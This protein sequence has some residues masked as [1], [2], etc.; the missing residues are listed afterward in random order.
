MELYE[1]LKSN[2]LFEGI[3]TK[4]IERLLGCLQSYIKTFRKNE[5]ILIEGTPIDFIAIVLTGRIFMEQEDMDGNSSIFVEIT[6]EHTLGDTFISVDIQQ[7]NVCY[8]AVTDSSLLVIHYE[9]FFRFCANACT[10][11]KKLLYNLISCI[12]QKN[13]Q[14]TDK[15]EILSQKTLRDKILTYLALL[16]RQQ[17]SLTVHSPLNRVEM[18][19]YLC[20]NRSAMTRELAAMRQEGLID[21]RGNVFQ[22]SSPE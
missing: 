15:L 22:T 9:H 17:G 8:K 11:H 6:P 20:V 13:R 19:D 12:A 10:C 5:Y 3:G 2:P 21:F 7:S 4:D 14:L 18:A 1:L 16:K